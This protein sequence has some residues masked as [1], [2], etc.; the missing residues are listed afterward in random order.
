MRC[1]AARGGFSLLAAT[2]LATSLLFMTGEA[3][4]FGDS[5]IPTPIDAPASEMAAT[6]LATCARNGSRHDCHQEIAGLPIRSGDPDDSGNAAKDVFLV[7]SPFPGATGGDQ[8][9][10]SP[11]NRPSAD[12]LTQAGPTPTGPV[13]GG[14]D[15]AGSATASPG[16]GY[17]TIF[18]QQ[19]PSTL[20]VI[21]ILL[22][23]IA[24]SVLIVMLGRRSAG[25]P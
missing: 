6:M 19:V 24:S 10:A 9:D 12:P 5:P 25:G 16:E 17:I 13:E 7:G 23:G 3:S 14:V 21:L 1:S 22:I 18:Q 8:P 2:L 4:A 20:A 11:T 15:G